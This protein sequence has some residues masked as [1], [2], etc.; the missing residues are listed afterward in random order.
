MRGS[1]FS[2]N[3]STSESGLSIAE[4]ASRAQSNWS[5]TGDWNFSSSTSAPT[6]KLYEDYTI[7]VNR[8]DGRAYTTIALD[9]GTTLDTLVTRLNSYVD[10]ELKD[11]IITINPKSG[12]YYITG[13]LADELGSGIKKIAKYTK[14][15][16]GGGEPLF[17]DDEI[18][19]ANVP[20]TNKNNNAIFIN[21]NKL[22]ELILAFIKESSAGRT[23]QEIND[24]IYPQMNDNFET[25]N[26]RVRT[27]LTYLRKKG[28]I[29]NIGSDT[30]SI[31]IAK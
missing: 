31:W 25:K 30:K 23:R 3:D 17:K 12:Q 11:G 27:A 4:I 1:Y 28:L 14:I 29:E 10:A 24:Y 16:S 26:S 5:D 20:L 22:K 9:G 8:P 15:Y 19:I 7:V 6:L 13:G 21:N 18:F 2:I